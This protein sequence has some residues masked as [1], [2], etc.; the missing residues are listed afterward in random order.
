MKSFLAIALLLFLGIASAL[1]FGRDFSETAQSLEYDDEQEGLKEAVV[2]NFSHVAAENTPKG[3]AA[4]KFAELVEERSA[5]K[6]KV[7]VYSNGSLYNDKNEYE[8]LK[9]GHVQMIAPATSKMTI[10][11]PSWQI[12]DLPFAFRNVSEVKA[13]YE[14][15]TG[16]ALLGEL[17]E[18]GLK[19]MTFWYNGFKQITSNKHPLI[20]P[21]DFEQMHFRIMPSPVLKAQFEA[22]GA[23]TSELPFNETYNNLEVDFIDGQENTIS[24]IYTKKLYIEQAHMTISNH[25][26][27]GYVVLM[28]EDFWEQLTDSHQQI[29]TETMEET[30]AWIERHSIEMNDAYLRQMKRDES[31]EIHYLTP[32]EREEWQKAMEAVYRRPSTLTEN[33]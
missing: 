11:F 15:A 32:A 25:G 13:I 17:E 9:S 7:N 5:G 8:A 3:M 14:G 21:E 30:T 18:D 22:L 4:R 19:G 31:I 12:L 2:I 26:Y 16:E 29:L 28:N 23:S 10:H 33:K 27:L 24:N 6:I 20:M 1:F